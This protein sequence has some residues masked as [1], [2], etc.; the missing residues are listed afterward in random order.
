GPAIS[1]SSTR[2]WRRSRS[3]FWCLSSGQP[4]CSVVPRWRR[5]EPMVARAEALSKPLV[6]PTLLKQSAGAALVT[7]ALTIL[8]VRIKTVDTNEA[9]SFDT[10]FSSVAWA[11]IGVG[12]AYLGLGLVRNGLSLVA[13]IASLVVVAAQGSLL[14]WGGPA[15]ELYLPFDDP[16]VNWVVVL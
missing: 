10:R 13:L 2:T 9:L 1:V 5:S 16:V 4:G 7:A 6:I 8:M 11:S 3:L 12:L 15:K 14:L